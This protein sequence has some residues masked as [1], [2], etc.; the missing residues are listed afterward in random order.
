MAKLVYAL[1]QSLDGYV[2]H[3]APGFPPPG[4]ALFQ[5]FIEH[6]RGLSGSL[7]GRRMYEVMRVWDDDAGWGPAELEFAQAWRAQP[8]FVVSRTLKEVGPN[9]SLIAGDVEAAVR[10]LKAERDGEMEVAGPELAAGLGEL[11]LIDEYHIYLRPFVVGGGKPYFARARPA[12]RLLGSER[13]GE[14]AL[15]LRYA[16][17]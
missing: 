8:K 7:Y 1:N 5:H 17:G 15:R 2:D 14:D 13:I 6:A 9:A 4:E 16:S 10:A 11:G 3:D 12:L